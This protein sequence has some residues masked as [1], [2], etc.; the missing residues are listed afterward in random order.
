MIVC[1]FFTQG[2]TTYLVAGD[3]GKERG[4]GC[5]NQLHDS[6]QLVYVISA[7]EQWL[8]C[9]QF[10]HDATHRPN[11]HW[12]YSISKSLRSDSPHPITITSHKH[13]SHSHREPCLLLLEGCKLLQDLCQARYTLL[14]H[15][16]PAL[17]FCLVNS[18][19]FRTYSCIYFSQ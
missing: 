14:F 5:A 11:I 16:D 8:A 13:A 6:C 1:H 19:C 3:L 9:D 7:W 4:L 17:V 12:K 15:T 2:K 18:E 10:R